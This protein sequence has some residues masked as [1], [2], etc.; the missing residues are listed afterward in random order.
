MSSTSNTIST[1]FSSASFA[2]SRSIGS[3]SSTPTL[4]AKIMHNLKPTDSCYICLSELNS[5]K[6]L[7]CERGC[8]NAVHAAC[9]TDK[10][11]RCGLCRKPLDQTGRYYTR[12]DTGELQP[13]RTFILAQEDPD[14]VR[15]GC[16]FTFL[17]LFANNPLTSNYQARGTQHFYGFG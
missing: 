2:Q 6:W 8:G 4:A 10:L 15:S 5:R 7:I 11:K 16:F 12:N 1:S 9:V 3:T 14:P 13:G 17:S